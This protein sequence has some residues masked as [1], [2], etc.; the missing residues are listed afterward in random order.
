[1]SEYLSFLYDVLG[2]YMP[3][4]NPDGSIAAGAAGVDWSYIV[5]G[6]LLVVVVYSVFKIIGGMICRIF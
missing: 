2:E 1:M 4:I 5:A 3:V 6:V